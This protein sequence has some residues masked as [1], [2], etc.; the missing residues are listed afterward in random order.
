MSATEQ[1]NLPLGVLGAMV[2]D[3]GVIHLRRGDRLVF[4]TDGVTEC[5]SPQEEEFGEERLRE[6]LKRIPMPTLQWPEIA[7]SLLSFGTRRATL[8][9]TT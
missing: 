9:T 3:E 4:Y 8:L 2:Y 6:V 5:P 7:C 1:A